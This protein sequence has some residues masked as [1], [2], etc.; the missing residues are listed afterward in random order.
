MMEAI[1]NKSPPKLSERYSKTLRLIVKNMLKKDP[2]ER[3]SVNNLLRKKYFLRY[4]ENFEEAKKCLAGYLRTVE[5][6]KNVKKKGT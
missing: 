4:Q 3:T 6:E 5:A 1:T 2:V